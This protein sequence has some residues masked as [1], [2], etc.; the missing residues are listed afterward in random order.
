MKNAILLMAILISSSAFASIRPVKIQCDPLGPVINGTLEMANNLKDGTIQCTGG[1]MDGDNDSWVDIGD[2]VL[3]AGGNEYRSAQHVVYELGKYLDVCTI[4]NFIQLW[5]YD[6]WSPAVDVV[7][8]PKN[9]LRAM[10]LNVQFSKFGSKD[11]G[12]LSIGD[13]SDCTIKF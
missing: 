7:L 12:A 9:S 1:S 13:G 4:D 3:R 6:R 2:L 10:K 5:R 11:S 8:F